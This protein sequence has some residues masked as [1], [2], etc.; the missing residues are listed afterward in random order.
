MGEHRLMLKGA[1]IAL[2]FGFAMIILGLTPNLWKVVIQ[3][4]R[5]FSEEVWGV[6][7]GMRQINSPAGQREPLLGL[8]GVVF[9]LLGLW[10]YL[11]A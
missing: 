5:N 7:P 3:G 10:A 4:I 11:S 8:L 2:T 9:V 1:T 6:P